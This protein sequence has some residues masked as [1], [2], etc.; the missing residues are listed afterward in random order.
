M[1]YTQNGEAQIGRQSEPFSQDGY[2]RLEGTAL[3]SEGESLKE[4]SR[5]GFF[6]HRVLATGN[7]QHGW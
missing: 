4:T 6:L 2:V 3:W 7:T 5:A 1:K